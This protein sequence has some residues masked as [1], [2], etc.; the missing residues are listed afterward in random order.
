MWFWLFNLS[1][2]VNLFLMFY[3]RWLLKSIG[4]FSK[5]TQKISD[6]IYKFNQHMKSIY[7]LEMF[8]G[9]ET[10]KSLLDHGVELTSKLDDIDFIINEEE[11]LEEIATTTE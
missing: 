5:E 4:D 2:V 7:E 1:I 3:I 8:Y 10:L 11:D 6:M 9:D